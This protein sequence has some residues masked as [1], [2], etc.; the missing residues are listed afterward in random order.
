MNG[1]SIVIPCFNESRRITKTFV[2]LNQDIKELGNLFRHYEIVFVNDGSKDN[3][4]NLLNSF[5]ENKNTTIKVVSYPMNSGKGYAV[6][7]GLLASKYFTKII[8]DADYSIRLSEIAKIPS[9]ENWVIIKGRRRQVLK[10]PFHRRMVGRAWHFLVLTL[11]GIEADSQAPFTLLQLP[12]Q[13]YKNLE[14][15]GFAFDV[16]I[17]YKL[18]RMHYFI[19]EHPVDY[20]DAQGSKVSLKKSIK[21]FF[22]ILR[23]VKEKKKK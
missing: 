1:I 16:E 13:F 10:Q 2:M 3:T 19:Y 5:G 17:I 9:W 7:R 12:R 4:L 11:A 6:K 20:Y 21:M 23:I 14:V 15:K 18:Q 22:D 8:L